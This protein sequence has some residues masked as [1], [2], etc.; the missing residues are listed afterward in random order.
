[1]ANDELARAKRKTLA[2]ERAKF[3]L[4][5]R[6]DT[7]DWELDELQPKIKALEEAAAND[8]LP[9]FGSVVDEG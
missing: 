2:Y 3:R 8:E 7:I 5:Q 9:E 1:M 6:L 4:Q